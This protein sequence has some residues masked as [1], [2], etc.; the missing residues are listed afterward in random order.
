MNDRFLSYF[1][2]NRFRFFVTSTFI[3]M[4]PLLYS[5][6][7]I[8][9]CGGE[10][11]EGYNL[12]FTKPVWNDEISYYKQVESIISYGKPLGYYGYNGEHALYGTFGP[13]GIAILIPYVIFGKIFG[14][15]LYSPCLANIFFLCLANLI[16]ILLTSPKLRDLKYILLANIFLYM[17][18]IFSITAM[19]ESIRCFFAIVLAGMIFRLLWRDTSKIFKY[20]IVPIFIVYAAQVYLILVLVVP[21]YVFIIM[22]NRN[23]WLRFIIALIITVIVGGLESFILSCISYSY[24]ESQLG[25]IIKTLFENGIISGILVTIRFILNGLRSID[26]FS[27]ISNSMV[28]N[29]VYPWI[30]FTY[31]FIIITIMY[32]YYKKYLSINEDKNEVVLAFFLP[33]FLIS[34]ITFYSPGPV[35][36]RGLNVALSFSIFLCSLSNNKK[37]M[38]S[39][40]IM[41]LLGF[42]PCY[43]MFN[44]YCNGR[45][46]DKSY[47]EEFQTKKENLQKII[48]VSP[49][50]TRWE[51]TVAVYYDFIDVTLSIPSGAG[52]QF[53]F[54]PKSTDAKYAFIN[55]PISDENLFTLKNI[56]L[57]DGYYFIYEDDNC[58]IL[59]NSKYSLN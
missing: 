29:S 38:K 14:W 15:N 4:I 36:I 48:E 20:I 59:I 11:G 40:I 58:L 19:S 2:N 46:I 41:S 28:E 23:I 12:F 47:K 57:N 52:L 44:Q 54:Q 5:L 32:L 53:M 39:F 6:L 34:H 8:F 1:K 33:A 10:L 7:G 27:L 31:W 18:V 45:F 49:D 56:L 50:K 37:L 17:N 22:K 42:L 16:F 3:I 21:I 51:N 13:W 55:K 43:T 25:I 9:I 30:T 26:L 24:V 35:L